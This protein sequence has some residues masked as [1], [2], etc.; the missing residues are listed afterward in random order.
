MRKNPVYRSLVALVKAEYPFD[1]ALQDRA[2]QFLNGLK[3]WGNEHLATKL[4]IELV[5]SSAGSP[6]GFVESLLSL[7]S[8]PNSTV[9]EAALSF[10]QNT[11]L[12]SSLS[13]RCN[14]VESGLISKVLTIVQPHTQPISGNEEML[15][16]LIRIIQNYIELAAPLFV[17]KLGITATVDAFNH[18]E[19]IF[20]KVVLPSSQFMCFL[21]VPG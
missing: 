11:Q 4:T 12:Y 13:V 18:R 9:V 6:S 14:F 21:I 15:H 3:P 7:M 2:A 16:T 8:C 19:M 1:N 20:R 10:L 5:P 17:R